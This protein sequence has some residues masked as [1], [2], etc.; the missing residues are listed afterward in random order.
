MESIKELL[1]TEDEETQVKI[2]KNLAGAPVIDLIV[3]L[4][5]RTGQVAFVQPVGGQLDMDTVY[6]VLDMA[7]EWLRAFEL[8]NIKPKEKDDGGERTE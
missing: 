1:G 8:K 7:R 6:K 3:R 4:D 2:I 5:G